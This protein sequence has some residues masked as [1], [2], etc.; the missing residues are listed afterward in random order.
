[1]TEMQIAQVAN[2][3]DRHDQRDVQEAG[4]LPIHHLTL[5]PPLH[6]THEI[7]E[8]DK[9]GGKAQEELDDVVAQGVVIQVAVTEVEEVKIGES[10]AKA[11]I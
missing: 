1:M 11:V 10:K 7:A 2:L 9:E 5:L 3:L 4:H 8:I 6:G